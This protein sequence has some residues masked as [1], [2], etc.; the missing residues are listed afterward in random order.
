[1]SVEVMREQEILQEAT[2]I[3]LEHLGPAKMARL[4]SSWQSG[5]GDYL[6]LREEL[7][8]DASVES[9]FEAIRSY[10]QQ[11]DVSSQ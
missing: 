11:A 2:E 4:W 1:M 8:A 9:L 10:Q 7:F 3:L 5:R 6:L